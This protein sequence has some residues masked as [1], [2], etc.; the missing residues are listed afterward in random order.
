MSQK[1][2]DVKAAVQNAVVQH[3][4]AVVDCKQQALATLRNMVAERKE[5]ENT[6]YRKSN[7]MLYAI[8]QKCYTAHHGMLG[9]DKQAQER[10]A[11]LN[12]FIA[13]Q[14]YRFTDATPLVT[15]VVKCV[16]GVDRRRVSAYSIVLR[17][18]IKQNVLL[19]NLPVW[20]EENGGVEQIRLGK[21]LNYKTTKQ[22][23]E[24]GQNALVKAD[25]LAV[26]K[27]DALS[28]EANGDF[29]GQECLLIA[30]QQADG[31]FAV[32]GVVRSQG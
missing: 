22:K 15:K 7:E 1:T 20:I 29:E 2:T 25:V 16:F 17:E 8:L 9:N 32:R 27:G 14:G 3:D 26:A 13:E 10:R 4:T 24:I 12:Q 6:A 28:K 18:A 31:T 5:W 23:A 30:T 19:Q 21:S 11:G